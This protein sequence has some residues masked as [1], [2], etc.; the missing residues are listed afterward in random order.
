MI[1]N[2]HFIHLMKRHEDIYIQAMQPDRIICCPTSSSLQD[3]SI[4][5]TDLESH[6]LIPL[7]GGG[8]YVS[9]N[10]EK[11]VFSGEDL[12]VNNSVRTRVLDV[13]FPPNE[14]DA[15]IYR[16]SN[17]ITLGSNAVDEFDEVLP[18]SYNRYISSFKSVPEAAAILTDL[19]VYLKK[20][21]KLQR[22][23]DGKRLRLRSSLVT[24]I[25]T[26]WNETTEALKELGMMSV[27]TK[28]DHD[29]RLGQVVETYMMNKIAST[30]LPWFKDSTYKADR[31]IH[32]QIMSLRDRT[33]SDLG[34]P[35][36]FQTNH[37]NAI[38]EICHLQ[39][40]LTPVDKLSVLK[41]VSTLIREDV[42]KNFERNNYVSDV[43]LA[44][45]DL[46]T[47]IIY[48]IIQAS[49]VYIDIPA[50]IRF[51]L[52]FHFVSSSQ[53][54]LGFTLCNF[55]V[56]IAWFIDQ[57]MLNEKVTVVSNSIVLSPSFTN[58]SVFGEDD[59]DFPRRPCLPVPSG[60]KRAV[61][62]INTMTSATTLFSPSPHISRN[63]TTIDENNTHDGDENNKENKNDPVYKGDGEKTNS[64]P[65]REKMKE[66]QAPPTNNSLL[67]A[68]PPK[69]TTAI[70]PAPSLHQASKLNQMLYILNSNSHPR[71]QK[72]KV[73]TE[74]GRKSVIK[75]TACRDGYFASVDSS[76]HLYTWGEPG[77]GRL[78]HSLT[79]DLDSII[80]NN[81]PTRVLGSITEISVEDV[82]LGRFHGVALSKEGAIYTWGD[83]RCGQIG[84]AANPDMLADIESVLGTHESEMIRSSGSRHLDD[85]S[86]AK[87]LQRTVTSASESNTTSCL[88]SFSSS[89]CN[90]FRKK[91]SNLSKTDGELSQ[92][93]ADLRLNFV[94]MQDLSYSVFVPRQVVSLNQ[95][96][97]RAI[98][99]G[100]FHSL[101]LSETGLVFS[102]GRGAN[103]RLGQ[104]ISRLK[105]NN[106]QQSTCLH[107][108]DLSYAE[109]GYVIFPWVDKDLLTSSSEKFT[110]DENFVVVDIAAGHSHSIATT[111][112]GQVY[113]WGCGS[114]GRL[115]HGDHCDEYLPKC[116]MTLLDADVKIT[117]VSA[118]AA[119]SVFL[120]ES[121][122]LYGCGLDNF[123]QVDALPLQDSTEKFLSTSTSQSPPT[124]LPSTC[125][126]AISTNDMALT[127]NCKVDKISIVYPLPIVVKAFDGAYQAA[128]D[129]PH[130]NEYKNQS[131][132][133]IV[134]NMACGDHFTM[135]ITCKG[136][137]YA[138]GLG[139]SKRYSQINSMHGDGYQDN[140]TDTSISSPAPLAS[141]L[142]NSSRNLVAAISGLNKELIT[143]GDDLW[144]S[145]IQHKG[146]SI[147][148]ISCGSNNALM[149]CRAVDY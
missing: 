120:S 20:V 13:E 46:I 89:K 142:E 37:E 109:P 105:G 33:Q 78:G 136:S 55:R 41:R 64:S 60:A 27:V 86:P 42:Q 113:S 115:G 8:E 45:D 72:L 137:I 48:I 118:G 149:H 95:I 110:M 106:F 98:A 34:V 127:S 6:V 38:R 54:H 47:I 68:S 116:I 130:D 107:Q 123:S 76:G 43:E 73:P 61:E 102:W 29:I 63:S 125:N 26:K 96:K 132:G 145:V 139:Y 52:K 88:L 101:C 77:C 111:A 104:H 99:C 25:Q 70:S 134:V 10:G 31:A 51:I 128:S 93:N 87:S 19:D 30:M 69:L 83:N 117:K 14:Y 135:A 39:H 15:I 144:N 108:D 148:N 3:V 24:E 124:S 79:F 84:L 22:N 4:H 103:G 74:G 140:P 50:D 92:S 133:E 143:I 82:S 57:V 114:Y 1:S 65:S 21:C 122:R 71:V 36:E 131:Y 90:D 100:S 97:M 91:S 44:T 66:Q 35:A 5:R 59:L 119:H 56:A 141:E 147:L 94:A 85:L 2:D 80:P 67:Q 62:L 75:K 138:W 16:V 49:R 146:E 53:S 126:A 32:L 129:T 121:G 40:A 17:M 81:M 112:T 12:I 23:E 9:L 7:G 18:E 28:D 11:V 58:N